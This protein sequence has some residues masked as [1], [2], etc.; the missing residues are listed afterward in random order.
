MTDLYCSGDENGNY[1]S[2]KL[3]DFIILGPQKTGTT[4]LHSFLAL[5]PNIKKSKF[6]RAAFEE[7]QFFNRNNYVKGINW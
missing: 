6:T 2:V 5:H 3:P 7:I 4:A 1:H